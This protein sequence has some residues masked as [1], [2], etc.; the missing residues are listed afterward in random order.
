MS[1]TGGGR[2]RQGVAFA[3]R[4]F[5]KER[6]GGGDT[7]ESG[8]DGVETLTKREM[9]VRELLK[10]KSARPLSVS[11]SSSIVVR[12]DSL[13]WSLGE[14]REG[15]MRLAVYRLYSCCALLIK[16]HVSC[17]ETSVLVAHTCAA[18]TNFDGRGGVWTF[19]WYFFCNRP[20]SL[21]WRWK[22]N[23][24]YLFI[25]DKTKCYV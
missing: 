8:G 14:L 17:D 12:L 3:L 4:G 2:C 5:P 1:A 13:R 7:C 22:L 19:F 23:E 20:S 9:G 16:F 6:G 25:E 24:R 18:V 15:V 10:S 21:L 11:S